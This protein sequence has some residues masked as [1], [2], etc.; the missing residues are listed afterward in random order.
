[1]GQGDVQGFRVIAAVIGQAGGHV[2]AIFKPGDQVAAA[3]FHRV[4][5][6][7]V[8]QQVNQPLQK[9]G[10]F[11]PPRAAV[12]LHRSSVGE[13]A[14]Y[15]GLDVGNVVGAGVH[16]A[17]QDGG[18]AGGGG[19]KVGAHAGVDHRANA[20]DPALA[21]GG[22][23][24]VLDMVS[25]MGGGLVVFRA[26]LGPLD[27]AA[28]LHGAE[29]GDHLIGVHRDFAAETAPYFRG[30]DP[31]FMLRHPGDQRAEEPADM[32]VLGGAP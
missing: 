3:H 6:Q 18:N 19:G 13:T 17:V 16:Q 23:L 32:G 1:M 8:G 25:A 24:R 9:E 21:G 31:D 20:G 26:G 5:P 11:R 28:Q 12:G 2:A 30:D 7:P 27:R 22:H 14:V 10:S 29:S 15:I 4:H